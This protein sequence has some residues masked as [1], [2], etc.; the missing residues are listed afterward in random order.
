MSASDLP[1]VLHALLIAAALLLWF[2]LGWKRYAI[3]RG[4]DAIL[5]LRSAWWDLATSNPEWQRS[6]ACRAF[7]RMLEELAESLPKCS[8]GLAVTIWLTGLRLRDSNVSDVVIA[9]LPEPKLREQARVILDTALVAVGTTMMRQ[10]IFALSLA[11]LVV[12]V[13]LIAILTVTVVRRGLPGLT[14][15]P[16][17]IARQMRGLARPALVYALAIG[18]AMAA[19]ESGSVTARPGLTV[20]EMK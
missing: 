6:S 5:T 2:H 15:L 11:L 4:R 3:D 16:V 19:R 8:L 9:A 10:S 17:A 12:P 13:A 20:V 7:T 1:Y 18:I 14:S